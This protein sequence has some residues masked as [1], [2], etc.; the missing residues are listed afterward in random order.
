MGQPRCLHWAQTGFSSTDASSFDASSFTDAPN[1]L[2]LRFVP[3]SGCGPGVCCGLL[4][5]IVGL[6]RGPCQ[7]RH[8]DKSGGL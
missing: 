8:E 5:S 7:D 1:Y 6:A 3:A 2:S 4:W